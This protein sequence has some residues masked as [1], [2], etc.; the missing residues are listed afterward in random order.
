MKNSHILKFLPLCALCLISIIAVSCSTTRRLGE[1]EVLYNG[2][3]IKINPTGDEK[4]PS[5]LVSQLQQAVNVK[6]N[7]P[8]PLL[9]PYKRTPFPI[10]L[11]VY[12]NWN[13]SAGGIYGWLYRQLAKPPVLVTDV[14]ANMRTKMVEEILANNGYFGSTATFEEVLNKKNPKKATIEYTFDVSSPYRIDSIIYLKRPPVGLDGI[15][16]SLAR[17]NE[18][19]QKGSIFSVD[20]LSAFRV[21][22]ANNVRNRGYYYFRPEYLEFL[23]DTFLTPHAVALRLDYADNIPSI[24]LRKYRTRNIITLLQRNEIYSPGTPDTLH[25]DRGELIIMRPQRVRKNLI[26]CCITFR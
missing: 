3:K 4:I 10:G 26:T 23:A 18:W 16:D 14:R 24:A 11:W 25:T 20:S 13:D 5:A 6:P 21:K 15:V 22:V 19:L 7:N 9:S 12:N 2:M 1:D 17:H 8:Y